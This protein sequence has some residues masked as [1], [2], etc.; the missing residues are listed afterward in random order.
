MTQLLS[1]LSTSVETAKT[2]KKTWTLKN[3]LWACALSLAL[4]LPWK[5]S[6]QGQISP[7][8]KKDSIESVVSVP[9]QSNLKINGWVYLWSNRTPLLSTPLGDKPAFRFTIDISDSKTWLWASVIRFDD[10]DKSMDNP[11]SQLTMIDLYKTIKPWKEISITFLWEYVN[12]DKM[13]WA[14]SFTP[15]VWCNYNA[16][17]WWSFD[18]RACHTFQKWKDVEDF[19]IW[20]TKILNKT[21][22]LATQ[23]FYKYDWSHKLSWR[24]QAIFNL[25]NWLWFQMEFTA[26]DNKITPSG[27]LFFKY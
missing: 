21:L 3:V 10:F 18:T 14:D 22:S 12:I 5:A 11:A 23:A 25:G 13:P 15:I 2:E 8:T 26:R 27:W 19:R 20:V 16:R 6:A 4:I 17:K 9:A 1:T 7:E 24:F